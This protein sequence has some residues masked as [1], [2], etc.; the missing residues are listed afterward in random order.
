MNT[1]IPKSE[2]LKKRALDLHRSGEYN[3]EIARR[4]N[5]SST[6]IDRWVNA[7]KPVSH[8]E[9]MEVL[10]WA[11]PELPVLPFVPHITLTPQSKYRMAAP[12]HD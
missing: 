4:L 10:R 3:R 11:E 12:A 8:M 6:T 7:A 5:V 2:F 1:F 9:R